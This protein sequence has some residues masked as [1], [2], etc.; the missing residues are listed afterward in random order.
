MF[1]YRPSKNHYPS[2]H[3]Q[4]RF[5]PSCHCLSFHI[6]PRSH[7][8][9][10]FQTSSPSCCSRNYRLRVVQGRNLPPSLQISLLLPELFLFSYIS[11]FISCVSYSYIQYIILPTYKDFVW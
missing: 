3:I 11:P 10:Y 4:L 6:Q 9:S 2:Y 1:H 7:S 5:L 8:S